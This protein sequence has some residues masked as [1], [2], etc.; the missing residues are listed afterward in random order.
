MENLGLKA[1]CAA[2]VVTVLAAGCASVPSA[3]PYAGQESRQIKALSAAEIAAYAEGKGQ[4]FAK[5]AELNGYPGTMH[6]LELADQL[7]LTS[8]QKIA[9]ELLT[10][11]Q[12]AAYQRL[13]GYGGTGHHH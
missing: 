9:S 2:V 7:A 1:C 11:V 6:V 10:P 3:S 12:N 8:E 13:R 5:P 4:G